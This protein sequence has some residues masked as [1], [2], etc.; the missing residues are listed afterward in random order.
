MTAKGS[1]RPGSERPRIRGKSIH[2]GGEKL[3]VRGVTYGGFR[4]RE[5][6]S[7]FPPPSQVV[8]DFSA[9]A[10]AGVNT[11]R[12]YSVPQ[13]WLLDL[14]REHG[15]R[16]MVG[17]PW[18]QHVTFLDKRD[19]AASILRRVR[20][21]VRSCQGHPAVL[22]YA[23]GNEIPTSIV[24]WHGRRRIE[25]F[26]RRLC[27]A[28]RREDPGALVTYVNYPST[29]Y[30]DLPFIDL[31]CFNV[32]LESDATLESYLAR[33]QNLAGEKPLLLTELGLD[34]SRNGQEAQAAALEAQLRT[35]F[36][37]GCAGAFVFSWTDEWHRGGSDVLDWDFGLVD[38]ERRPKPALAAVSAAFAQPVA[39]PGQRASVVVCTYNGERWLRGC[40][41]A[42]DGLDYPAYE[43]IVVDDGSTDRTAEIAAEFP[44]FRL[45][46][47][48]NRG[49]SSARNLGLEV[50]TGDIVAYL[51][52]DARPDPSW[53]THLVRTLNASGHA[54]VGGPNIPPPDDGLVADCVAGAPGGPIHVLI[55]DT[56]AEHIP[57]CNMA[58]RKALL[59]EIG[60]FDSVFRVAGDDVDVCWRLQEAGLTVGFSPGAVVYHHRRSSVRAYLRQ[61]F[62]YGKA[63]ALLERK[64]P[65]RYNPA[66]HLTWGGRVYGNLLSPALSWRRGKVHYG[67]WGSGLFQ[68]VYQRASGLV[69]SLPLTPEWW[70][71][72]AL[73]AS[74]SSLGVLWRPLLLALP[75]LAFAVGA[76]LWEALLAAARAIFTHGRRSR[77]DAAVLLGL[78]AALHVLQPLA[79]LAGRVRHG[80]TPWRRRCP[81]TLAAPL[82]RT[83]D[84]WSE[85]WQTP[86][87]WLRRLESSLRGLSPATRRGGDFDRWDLELR[88]GILGVARMRMGVE[89]HGRGCQLVRFRSWP[90]PSHAGIAISL[91]LG[92]LSAVAA[93]TG[94]A[95]PAIVLGATAAALALRTLRDCCAAVGTLRRALAAQDEER[96]EESA[97]VL[98]LPRRFA[99]VP[100]AGEQPA[101]MAR[102]LR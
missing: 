99:S 42:L 38:R 75:L 66:G 43:V 44:Q 25:R 83:S 46:S 82:P 20:E 12:T 19:S 65:R 58:F 54:A 36:G 76:T 77:L 6:G 29:E 93:G 10:A 95:I 52:D 22:C 16:V 3:L 55:S 45:I 97:A 7:E 56:E 27:R 88:G 26:L 74:L 90:V 37:L 84:L 34:S 13:R 9:M 71:V 94:A 98:R 69:G 4:P 87:A 21:G 63:E 50:A 78:T 11:L 18:E 49:L 47:T 24:R 40:L 15:L 28:V 73:L 70:L 60:G 57:G 101:A 53:L 62:Q 91:A 100:A 1:L 81:A 68:S 32:F 67:T 102:S 23:V 51:D 85:T 31:V 48:P 72:I 2:A 59:Q 80:L 35:A 17:L 41:E 92:A 61:Q 33:L 30:L 5:D 8:E 64:W 79:R 86:A 96:I 14:A 89:E 39:G